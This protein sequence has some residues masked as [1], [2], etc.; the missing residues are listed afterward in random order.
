MKRRFLLLA[1]LVAHC[2]ATNAQPD[3]TIVI[4][5]TYDRYL[6]VDALL[7]DTV[8]GRFMFDMGTQLTLLDSSF[9]ARYGVRLSHIQTARI[10]GYGNREK[11][12]VYST[13]TLHFTLGAHSFASSPNVSYAFEYPL[14]E[15]SGLLGPTAFGG[16]ILAIDYAAGSLRI[17]PPEARDT[18]GNDRYERIPFTIN[19]TNF[20]TLPLT[21]VIDSARHRTV[22]GLVHIDTG[23][24]GS[25]T[26]NASGKQLRKWKK[27]A[28][29]WHT[30]SVPLLGI[31]GSGRIS[32]I[33]TQALR[34]GEA[35]IPAHEIT[36]QEE[37][38]AR[39]SLHIGAIGN[40]LLS[41][42]GSVIFDMEDNSL[43]LPRGKRFANKNRVNYSGFR[44]SY[45]SEWF[46]N[47][48]S[49]HPT[50][51]RDGDI[52]TRIDRRPIDSLSQEQLDTYFCTPDRRY[53]LTVL[54][55][56]EPLEIPVTNLN[57]KTLW[58]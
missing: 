40:A 15:I 51:V 54:R 49:H 28:L 23:D 44:L 47:G 12:A 1:A 57:D 32:V 5:M 31:N 37:S 45:I 36:I 55:D 38:Q 4:P 3:S 9:M 16:R 43:Y 52:V 8:R 56:G 35:V 18:L 34:L 6:Y 26:L 17:L 50:S 41:Q 27:Q 22:S 58:H 19:H 42:F 53:T 7:N 39:I 29:N 21:V 33:R 14:G 25:L 11:T 2:G 30:H 46:V 13:D 10:I 48:L 20:V 24:P